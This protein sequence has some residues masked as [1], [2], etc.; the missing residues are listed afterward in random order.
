VFNIKETIFILFLRFY[1]F[2]EEISEA[3]GYPIK[4]GVGQMFLVAVGACE[5]AE[6]IKADIY[7]HFDRAKED[8]IDIVYEDYQA[9]NGLFISCGIK[10]TLIARITDKKASEEFK[11]ILSNALADIIIEHYEPKLIK[12]LAKG[13]FFYLNE[14]ERGSVINNAG[15]LLKEDKNIQPGIFYRATRKNRIVKSIFEYLDLEREFNIEGFVNFRLSSYINE[16]SETLERA[17]EI[18]VAEREYNEFIRLLRYF[19]EIQECKINAVHLFQAQDGR[20]ML[21]DEDKKHISSEYFDELKTEVLDETINYDDL[22]ISTLITISPQKITIH[23]IESF[24]NKELVQTIMNVFTDRISL[25]SKCE[26]CGG[27]MS[28]KETNKYSL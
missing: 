20:Y 21:F 5:N 28:E 7:R 25:C 13:N 4:K 9:G 24:R 23:N 14:S 17:L 8:G 22:L 27:K 11:H 3:S 10:D 26:L 12:K 6:I 18:F 19:V 16:L 15:K 1:R 2:R